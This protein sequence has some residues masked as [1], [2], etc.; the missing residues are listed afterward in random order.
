[1]RKNRLRELLDAGKPSLGTHLFSS[2]PSITE[3]VGN[4]GAFDYVEFVAEYAPYDLYSLENLGRAIALFD[5]MSGMMKIEQQPRTYLA[6]R[7]VGAGLQNL[8][9][10]DVRSVADAEECVRAARAETPTTRGVHG[11]GM[12]RDVGHVLEVASPAY[13]QAL[14]DT[15]VAL[16]IEKREAVENLEAILS[17]PG[18]DMVQFGPG[19][20]SMSIG[21]P[22]QFDHPQVVEAER[23]VIET[24]L[25]KGVAPRA[26]IS[27]PG[28]AERYLK[29]GVRH[30][31][32]GED[33]SILYEWFR[34]SGG[35]MRALLSEVGAAAPA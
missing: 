26:E 8:L 12:R 33:V 2:W 6:V 10:A 5:H 4:A 16:M 3:L 23:H 14:E 20:Y 22:G 35:A 13:V 21:V 18:V 19:D 25:R 30:F 27:E 29:L 32:I 24:A 31:C 34:R 15:V 11:C 28:E 7:A 1:M 9:F 17:V